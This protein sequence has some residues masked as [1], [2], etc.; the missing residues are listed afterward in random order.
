MLGGKV[1]WTRFEFGVALGLAGGSFASTMLHN[2][3]QHYTT[4]CYPTTSL[5]TPQNTTTHCW[6]PTTLIF[7][8]HQGA[9]PPH[10]S[11]HYTTLL[12]HYICPHTTVT[13]HN[14]TYYVSSSPQCFPTTFVLCDTQTS[15][16][17][18]LQYATLP[19]S[20]PN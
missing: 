6:G 10:L 5:L 8:S 2:T 20:R 15:H 7:S 16:Y 9:K 14:K 1:Y 11:P 3:T 12:P 13:P 19:P 4:Q 17:T 18:T